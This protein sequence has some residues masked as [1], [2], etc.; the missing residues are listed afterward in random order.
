MKTTSLLNPPAVHEWT[1]PT[2]VKFRDIRSPYGTYYHDTTLPAVVAALDNAIQTGASVRLVLGDRTT[3]RAW[4]E[5]WDVTGRVSRS[6]GPIKVPILLPSA[7]SRSGGAILTDSIVRLFVNGREVY[8]HPTFSQ[9]LL[10]TAY[11][12]GQSYPATVLADNQVHA[13][14]KTATRAARWID[15]MECKRLT[16]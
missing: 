1:G 10:T 12:V 16:R 14:F 15:F 4:L 13:R 5:E 6:M 7:R 8:K 11:D 3:G 9:A 2:G